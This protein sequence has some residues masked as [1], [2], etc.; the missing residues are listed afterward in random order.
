MT[1]FGDLL[2]NLDYYDAVPSRLRVRTKEGV[3]FGGK[4]TE[5]D[6]IETVS[7]VQVYFR[8][9]GGAKMRVDISRG[10][11]ALKKLNPGRSGMGSTTTL[12]WVEKFDINTD[13]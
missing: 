6:D 5:I 9:D 7:T 1:D 12:G 11:P 13:T 3:T 10:T 4:V 8:D 2:D